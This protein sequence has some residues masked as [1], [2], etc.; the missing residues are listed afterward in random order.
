[1]TYG[2]QGNEPL[3][4]NFKR[5]APALVENFKLN[6]YRCWIATNYDRWKTVEK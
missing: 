6:S 2:L 5:R 3:A 1:M 4:G